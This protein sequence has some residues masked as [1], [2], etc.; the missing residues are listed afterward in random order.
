MTIDEAILK[1][2]SDVGII[3][4]A[5][6]TVAKWLKADTLSGKNGKGDGRLMINDKAVVAHN[7]QTGETVRISI[8]DDLPP[9]VRQRMRQKVQIASNTRREQES[10]AIGQ[11]NQIVK[12]ATLSGH[13]YLDRKGFRDE[14]ALVIA[15]EDLVAILGRGKPS[16]YLIA[17]RSAIVMPARIG[18][19]IKTVQLIWEDGTKKFLYGGSVSGASYRIATGRDTVTCE[20]YATGLTVRA[21][22]RSL[23]FNAS[24]L[25]CFSASNVA[26]VASRIKGRVVIAADHDQPLAQY[27]GRGA[28]EYFAEKSAKPYTMP[29]IVGDD[30]NDMHQRDGIFAVQRHL[31]D[32][33]RSVR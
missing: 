27:N 9:A 18:G 30:F 7:W 24:V 11:A 29:P 28:G 25:C 22:L 1:A 16:D 23:N 4:P 33:I 15:A 2:C 14:M 32:F 12:R 19:A 31:T 8:W 17:G 21:A 20:G 3:P 5:S 13:A 26:D 10:L 6:R